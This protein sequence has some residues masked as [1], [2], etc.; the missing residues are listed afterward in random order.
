MTI[1][2][3][4]VDDLRDHASKLSF[5]LGDT[6]LET[7]RALMEPALEVYRVLDG[8]EDEILPPRYP[9]G[10]TRRPDAAEN[11]FNAWAAKIEVKG[12]ATGP[13]VGRSVVLKDNVCLA[14]APLLNGTRALDGQDRP[15]Q[16]A[17]EH[18]RNLS[19][20]GRSSR[21]QR[22]AGHSRGLAGHVLRLADV[23]R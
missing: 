5:D 20:F 8:I 14:G 10:T 19:R 17:G 23:S 15:C 3:P 13:L 2:T 6:E 9:R 1:P 18:A 4:T 22:R 21:R 16:C 7:Y 11:T 12:A